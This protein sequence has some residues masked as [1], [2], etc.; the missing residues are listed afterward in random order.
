[1]ANTICAYCRNIIF[2]DQTALMKQQRNFCNHK[3]KD[4]YYS[5]RKVVKEPNTHCVQC[6]K[7][8]WRKPS[9]VAKYT[10]HFCCKA[11]HTLYQQQD[12]VALKCDE[13]GKIFYRKLSHAKKGATG[14]KF[15]SKKCVEVYGYRAFRK[16]KYDSANYKRPIKYCGIC[17]Y[18]Q[19]EE[20]LSIHWLDGKSTN[21]DDSNILV[22]CPNCKELI[23]A[24]LLPQYEN[25]G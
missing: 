1:M 14:L 9:Q 8:I 20:I 7:P 17:G 2:R 16:M 19:H 21:K 12:Q 15:C 5:K 23:K 11:C 4:A 18:S 24:G 25:R 6:G 10:K 3:C 13:C 22:V